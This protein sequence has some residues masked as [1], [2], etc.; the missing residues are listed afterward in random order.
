MAIK[1]LLQKPPQ[2]LKL[3]RGALNC[4]A[5]SPDRLWLA[6]GGD[7]NTVYVFTPKGELHWRRKKHTAPVESL[8]WS[9]DGRYLAS[10]A[11]DGTVWLWSFDGTD[12]RCIEGHKGIVAGIAWSPDGRCLVSGSD[13]RT[14]RLW[15]TVDGTELRRMEGHEDAIWS[16]DWSPDGRFLASG[17]GDRTVRL[18]SATSGGELRCL[19]GHTNQV[20]NI[21]WSP[22]S[23]RLASGGRDQTVRLWSA[24]NGTELHCLEGREGT[25][26]SIA[27]SPDG[28]CLALGSSQGA[29][30]LWS[31]D[32][33]TDVGSSTVCPRA[34][35]GKGGSRR[36]KGHAERVWGVVW[37]PDGSHLAAVARDGTLALWEVAAPLPPTPTTKSDD[38]V[39]WLLRQ[40]ATMGR[41]A[42]PWV[43][44][45]PDA[46]LV[47]S[48]GVLRAEGVQRSGA[49]CVAMHP[50][51]RRLASG[52]TDGHLRCWNLMDG[53]LLWTSIELSAEGI[54]KSVEQTL[55]VIQD[56]AWSPDGRYLAVGM[57]DGTISLWSASD[58][59]ELHRLTGHRAPVS[60]VAWS[61]NDGY[62]ASGSADR[63][64]RL[65]SVEEGV[66]LRCF[67]GHTDLVRS[68]AWSPDG[69]LL[70]SGAQDRT[71]RLWSATDGRE[72]RRLE[73]HTE[74]VYSV[75]WSQD[76]HRLASGSQDRTVRLW[77]V[78]DGREQ[79]RLDGHSGA[80]LNVAW[81]PDGTH[82]AS[83][84]IDGTVF[85]WKMLGAGVNGRSPLR[86][87][88]SQGYIWRLVWAPG[89]NFLVSSHAEDT[90]RFWDTRDLLPLQTSGRVPAHTFCPVGL[91]S[92]PAALLALHRLGIYPPLSLVHDLRTLLGGGTP[93]ALESLVTG[94]EG[95]KIRDLQALNWPS[96]AR[97]GL[98]AL[99]LHGL[100]NAGWQV[101]PDLTSDILSKLLTVAL[102]GDL[103]DPNA[104]LPPLVFLRQTIAGI[105][106]SLLT[107]IEALGPEVVAADPGLPL[108]L[109][110]R[111]TQLP[112][113]NSVQ[114]YLLGHHLMPAPKR[115]PIRTPLAFPSGGGFI[116]ALGTAVCPEHRRMEI[117][118]L[119]TRQYFLYFHHETKGDLLPTSRLRPTVIILDCSP[120]CR[121]AVERI[122]RPAAHALATT[123][124]RQGLPTVFVSAGGQPTVHLLEQ[125]TDLLTLL[126]QR[127][128]NPPDPVATFTVATALR[129]QFVGSNTAL[130]P[131]MLLLTQPQWGGETEGIIPSLP[132]LRALFVQDSALGRRVD[133]VWA[134][135]CE[136]WEMIRSDQY[137]HLPEVLGR[138]IG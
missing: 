83:G 84:S 87:F 77:S 47:S 29:V 11:D 46:D 108:R 63:T 3:S 128:P 6:L 69:R 134:E 72:L 19:T 57:E 28:E 122:I 9:P 67:K 76:G 7:D 45:F 94:P 96:A 59:V 81:S 111:V 104:P 112:R 117:E 55:R 92:L 102:A 130:D 126:T 137:V 61:P 22:D 133:P 21:A 101:P 80:V 123:L 12:L 125:P 23:H 53:R 48:L 18:W 119:F 95:E 52:H 79:C 127:S 115:S 32:E 66:E 8:A 17:S 114:R 93:L 73:G 132:H 65:W 24:Q 37:S 75:A 100:P 70:A 44:C 16:V 107:L 113:L 39:Q 91:S 20:S 85:V 105:D 36:P 131:I 30:R 62:L 33:D 60:S 82:L 121:G 1:R 71:I 35:E 41:R 74:L 14:L 56:L 43:P 99:L 88:L 97:T 86:C 118:R 110:Y 129:R 15:S 135:R 68:I 13:D 103:I 124:H 136:R 109:R 51:A 10:G 25:I 50:N 98:L 26:L 27:W 42:P 2:V 40:A 31:P 116:S 38:A 5:W 58:G 120:A 89:G 90:L 64:V 78:T 49:P 34:E 106:A 138:L 4:V 54:T